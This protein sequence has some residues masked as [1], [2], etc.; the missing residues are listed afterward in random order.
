DRVAFLGSR[1]R[2]G[3]PQAVATGAALD[4]VPGARD[5]C[6]A[7][8]RTI[9]L[10]P[11]ASLEVAF[12]LGDCG[13]RAEARA[14]VRSL[15]GTGAIGRALDETREFWDGLVSGVR[16]RT[17]RPAIDVMVNGWLAYQTV[18]CRLWARSAFY[19]S[20]GAFG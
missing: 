19:Q 5:A 16:I 3:C 20:G 17:P 12:L 14:L 8:Q 1:R 10:A 18:A 4:G 6:L 7:L 2:P 13:D 9:D 11:G 15:R